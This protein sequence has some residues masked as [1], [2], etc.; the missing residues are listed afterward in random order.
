MDGL[1]DVD[2]KHPLKVLGCSPHRIRSTSLILTGS[3]E[4]DSVP[5]RLPDD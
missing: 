4:K 1:W 2:I 3:E 5:Q